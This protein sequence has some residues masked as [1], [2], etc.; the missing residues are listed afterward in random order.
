MELGLLTTNSYHRNAQETVPVQAV[1]NWVV[2]GEEVA[3]LR[4]AI[5]LAHCRRI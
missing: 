5:D 1:G 2:V 4:I 3:L